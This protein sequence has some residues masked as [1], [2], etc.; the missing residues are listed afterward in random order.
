MAAEEMLHELYNQ[1]LTC[2][3]K[4]KELATVEKL[5]AAIKTNDTTKQLG[6]SMI[7][8]IIKLYSDKM[9]EGMD[10]M[11]DLCEDDHDEVR[12][13]A[14]LNLPVLCENKESCAKIASILGQLL[15]SGRARDGSTQPHHVLFVY[16]CGGAIHKDSFNSIL[17]LNIWTTEEGAE[18]ALVKSALHRLLSMDICKSL[19]SLLGHLKA[20]E[21]VKDEVEFQATVFAFLE[22][23]VRAAEAGL[24]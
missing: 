14:I 9:E 12:K 11:F 8:K 5:M 21:S 10:L 22:E 6:A 7:P 1:I 19:I 2:A 4:S 13:K 24:G 23:A 16:A 3:D 17:M 18:R 20:N 15:M